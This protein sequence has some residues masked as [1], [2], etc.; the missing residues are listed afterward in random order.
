MSKYLWCEDSGSGYQFWNALCKSLFPD[1][2]VESKRNNSRLRIAVEKIQAD[3]NDYYILMDAAADNPDVIR[4]YKRLQNNVSGKPNVHIISIHSFEF[5][6]LSFRFLAQWVFAEQ[7]DLL[8]KRHALLRA[9]ALLVMIVSNG[10]TANE[11]S[12]LKEIILHVQDINTEQIAAKL[13]Y[14]ITRNTGF[15]TDKGSLGPCFFVD[16]CDWH[17]R[18]PNDLCGLEHNKISAHAKAENLVEYSVLKRA[19]EGVGCK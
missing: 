9:S 6:L 12:E 7:D 13:L 15:E 14:E 11:L 10:G 18:Q 4:E 2:T 1:I 16:C 19:L 8:K 5:V 3:E 17:G